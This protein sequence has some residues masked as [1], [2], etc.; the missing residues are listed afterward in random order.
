MTVE[1]M[2]G[3]MVT[4]AENKEQQPTGKEYCKC[5]FLEGEKKTLLERLCAK[6]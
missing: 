6:K 3:V 1:Y 2:G 4:P 5:H